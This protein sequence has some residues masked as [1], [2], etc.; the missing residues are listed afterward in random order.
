MAGG[1]DRLY[2]LTCGHEKWHKG[3]VPIPPGVTTICPICTTYQGVVK[4]KA[5]D[6]APRR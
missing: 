2:V 4:V 5:E 3:L 6:D 1:T